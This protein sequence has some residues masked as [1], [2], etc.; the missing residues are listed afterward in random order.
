MVSSL[1]DLETAWDAA[2][3]R[4]VDTST[5]AQSVIDR[6]PRQLRGGLPDD[7]NSCRL[8]SRSVFKFKNDDHAGQF[9]FMRSQ[10]REGRIAPIGKAYDFSGLSCHFR[11]F[12]GL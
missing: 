2:R 12:C 4:R 7:N 1:G 3:Q 11:C 6:P 8:A 9:G 10:T 5:Y